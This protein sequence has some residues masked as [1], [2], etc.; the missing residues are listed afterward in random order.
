MKGPSLGPGREDITSPDQVA[1]SGQKASS[2]RKIK[3]QIPNTIV[4]PAQRVLQLKILVQQVRQPVG[5]ASE[6]GRRILR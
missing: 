1:P 4:T 5:V 6:Q 2:T 3:P